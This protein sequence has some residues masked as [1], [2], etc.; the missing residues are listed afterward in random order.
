M[1][2][3]L[4]ICV[5]LYVLLRYLACGILV[6]QPGIG[7]RSL[8]VEVQSPNHGTTREFPKRFVGDS[9]AVLVKNHCVTGRW[10]ISSHVGTEWLVEGVKA[11]NNA[12]EQPGRNKV[13]LLLWSNNVQKGK[14]ER[15]YSEY[16]LGR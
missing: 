15:H 7:S 3:L 14:C 5:Y 8:A 16:S 1:Y 6:P 13:F 9:G 4:C 12:R 10:T 11:V 2:L